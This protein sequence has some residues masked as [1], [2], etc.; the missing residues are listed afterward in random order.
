MFNIFRSEDTPKFYPYCKKEI[1]DTSD[2]NPI[3]VDIIHRE[4]AKEKQLRDFPT[5]SSGLLV[6][7]IFVVMP[8]FVLKSKTIRNTFAGVGFAFCAITLIQFW[9]RNKLWN[10]A[11]HHIRE[12]HDQIAIETIA[13]GVNILDKKIILTVETSKT[14]KKPKGAI[15]TTLLSEACINFR[16]PVILYL[17]LLFLKVDPS[18]KKKA[19]INAFLRCNDEKVRQFLIEIAPECE[20]NKVTIV[21]TQPEVVGFFAHK[22][23]KKGS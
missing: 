3:I 2:L 16:K 22:K 7:S 1:K 11:V 4:F 8:H 17:Y 12:G 23:K 21:D 18:V 13:Q 10:E 20:L 15:P 6:G 9:Q 5:I 14:Q 19:F